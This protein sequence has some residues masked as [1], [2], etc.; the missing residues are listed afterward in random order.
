[1]KNEKRGR[2]VIERGSGE[3]GIERARRL[4]RH[5]GFILAAVSLSITEDGT[6]SSSVAAVAMP[7]LRHVLYSYGVDA[8]CTYRCTA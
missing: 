5:R 7:R 3:C 1:M 2:D 4:V 6:R 8:C